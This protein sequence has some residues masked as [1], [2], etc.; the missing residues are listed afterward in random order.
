MA[1]SRAIITS[2]TAQSQSDQTGTT[3]F[4]ESKDSLVHAR[5]VTKKYKVGRQQIDALGGVSL[6]VKEGEFV[7]ITGTSGSGKSTLL[8]L[9][10]GLD[11]PTSG[12]IEIAGQ[13]LAKLRD[14]KL[15]RFRNSTIGFVFQFFYLQ[16]FLNLQTNIEVPA[17]FAKEKRKSRSF[18]SSRLA[19]IVGLTDR[20]RHLP[21]ELSGGQMQ[22]AAIARALQNHPRILLADE[23]TGNLDR[24]NAIAIFELFR[25]I[26][27]EQGMTIIV[28]THDLELARMADRA[29]HMSDGV[30]V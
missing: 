5:D 14:S 6:D 29:I 24:T 17:M 12:A 7:A 3:V 30:I 1:T 2:V 10:G 21:R 15:S 22:R 9:L 11:K 16:P 25:Q 8:H 26:Q 28:V 27:H 23:P 18:Q 4:P 13:D 20:L 19:A